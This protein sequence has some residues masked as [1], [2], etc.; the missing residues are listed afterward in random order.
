MG[1]ADSNRKKIGI[2][3]C[4]LGASGPEFLTHLHLP[5]EH[6]HQ[7]LGAWAVYDG[8]K[9]PV[10]ALTPTQENIVRAVCPGLKQCSLKPCFVKGKDLREMGLSG[11]KISAAME[12][13]CK[14]QWAGR[15]SSKEQALQFLE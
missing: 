8:Q 7:L 11:R 2:F 1:F 14:L 13:F 4:L 10:S 6:M 12:R 9:S 3:A 15:I 5:K